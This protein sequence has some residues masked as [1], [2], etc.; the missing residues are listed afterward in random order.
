MLS[1]GSQGSWRVPVKGNV[2]Y[3]AL[4]NPCLL[5]PSHVHSDSSQSDL[6]VHLVTF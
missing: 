2:I 6:S 1:M 3:V 4:D 5:V